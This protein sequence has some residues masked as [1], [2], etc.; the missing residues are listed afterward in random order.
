MV[1]GLM[2]WGKKRPALQGGRGAHGVGEEEANA[3]GRKGRRP[4]RAEMRS[5]RV[6]LL[7]MLE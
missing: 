4:G 7:R 1:M 5:S 2:A 6:E 3:A